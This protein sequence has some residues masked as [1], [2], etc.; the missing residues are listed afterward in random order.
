MNPYKCQPV[1]A[2][3]ADSLRSLA[4][5]QVYQEA[6]DAGRWGCVRSG[7][8]DARR[9][10]GASG[11]WRHRSLRGLC[12]RLRYGRSGGGA[13]RRRHGRAELGGI[14]EMLDGLAASAGLSFQHCKV[15]AKD[16]EMAAPLLVTDEEEDLRYA[17]CPAHGQ[18]G[19][20]A[21]CGVRVMADSTSW[22]RLHTG[23]QRRV[24]RDAVTGE[25]SVG[26]EDFINN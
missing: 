26:G 22:T 2:S 24:A 23:A 8:G 12:V 9:A 19:A 14:V 1:D 17:C 15:D 16:M 3:D 18:E 10:S 11:R 25:L 21:L 13:G 6:A 5:C 4:L 20:S 7:G